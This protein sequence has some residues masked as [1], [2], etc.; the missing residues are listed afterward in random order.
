MPHH[1]KIKDFEERGYIPIT[2]DMELNFTGEEQMLGEFL[3][4]DTLQESGGNYIAT[5]LISLPVS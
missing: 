1:I 3:R 4:S 2:E 5:I